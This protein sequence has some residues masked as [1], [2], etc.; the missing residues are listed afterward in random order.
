MNTQRPTKLTDPFFGLVVFSI[1]SGFMGLA[2]LVAPRIILPWFEVNEEVNS[3]TYMLGFVLIASSFY[4][5]ASGIGKDRF[6]AKLT[7]Y[8]R[9]ASPLITII[10][11]IDGNVPVNFV[12]LS[13]LDAS[14]GIWT[15]YSLKKSQSADTRLSTRPVRGVQSKEV[16]N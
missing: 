2:L 5:L 1:Y 13:I 9:L 12:L 10:L 16:S 11:Y 6:F 15:Y 3:F 7:V 14:G 8:T 4:Y